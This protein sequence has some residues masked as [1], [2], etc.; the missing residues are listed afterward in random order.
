MQ[1]DNCPSHTEIIISNSGPVVIESHTRPGGD[2]IYHLLEL[3]TGIDLLDL[4]A[5]IST[6][7]LPD[8]APCAKSES[9]FSAIWYSSP[10][11][12]EN[13]I[14][15]NVAGIKEARDLHNVK[16]ITLL[17]QPG[18]T[19]RPVKNSFDRSAYAIA[20]G[21]SADE[22]LICAQNALSMVT[23]NYKHP[24]ENSIKLCGVKH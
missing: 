19:A 12:N 13:F 7:D 15:D 1:F 17:A 8:A 4:V 24:E 10:E 21:L 5:R 9:C 3:S 11:G 16:D 14:L 20:T 6:N 18:D 2:N 22:A 23:F